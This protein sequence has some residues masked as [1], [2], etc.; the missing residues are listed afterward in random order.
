M[1][2]GLIPDPKGDTWR[3]IASLA[4]EVSEGNTRS[5]IQMASIEAELKRLGIV[6]N[7]LAAR[8]IM[9]RQ[10]LYEVNLGITNRVTAL[11]SSA[12]TLRWVVGTIGLGGLATAIKAFF[13]GGK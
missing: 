11:E 8:D 1:Q 12:S 4:R 6:L 13:W 3:E 9:D 7:E 5:E 2:N 10:A